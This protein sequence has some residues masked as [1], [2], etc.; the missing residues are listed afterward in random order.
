MYGQDTWKVNR[1][2]TLDYGLRWAYIGPTYTVKPYLE[3]YFDPAKY[4]PSQAVII[5]TRNTNVPA[6]IF[7]GEICTASTPVNPVGDTEPNPCRNPGGS[8]LAA[9]M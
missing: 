9:K 5:D 2:L 3:Y 1:R 4:D 6:N 8:L 7:N